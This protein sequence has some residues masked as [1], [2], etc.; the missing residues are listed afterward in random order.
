[1]LCP[2]CRDAHLQMHSTPCGAM[3]ETCPRCRGLW[4]ECGQI[5]E[6]V[7]H[8]EEF[9]K[10]FEHGPSDPHPGDRPCPRCVSPLSEGRLPYEDV[11]VDA[12]PSCGGLWFDAAEV[13]RIVHEEDQTLR[14]DEPAAEAD[15]HVRE[16]AEDRF[17]SLAAG[18]FALPNL[19]LRSA[20]TLTVL[21]GIL[22]LVLITVVQLGYVDGRL[23]FLLG[24][25]FAVCQYTFG[26][27]IMDLSLGYLYAFDWVTPRRLPEHLR[28]FVERV[29]AEHG[30]RFPSFGLIRDGAPAA[31]TYGHHPNN[32]RVVIS[33]GLLE[34]LEPAEVEAVVAHE[35]G[36][37]RNWDMALMTVANLVPFLLYY[38]YRF[39]MDL[40]ARGKGKGKDY[41]WAVSA[42]AYVLFIVSEYIVLWFSRTREYFADRFSGQVTGNANTLASALVKIAYGLAA[43]PQTAEAADDA[44][45]KKS[46]V[47][48]NRIDALG[49]LNIFDRKAAVGLVMA[50]S[51]GTQT[52]LD[53]EQV[54]GAMQWDLWNPWAKY[55]ELHSTHPLVARR[56]IALADHAAQQ[57]HDPFI[58]FDRRKP[59]S[60]W[61]NF[62]V[63]LLILALPT[64]GFLAGLVAFGFSMALNPL[65]WHQNLVWLAWAVGLAGVGSLVKTTFMYR[66]DFSP[67]LAVAALLHKVN[68]S[69]VR[70]VPA[71]LTGKIIGK[72][73]PGLI[74][75]EDFVLKDRTGIIFLNYRQPLAVW[76]WFFGMFRAAQ[77][78]GKEVRVRG[79]Y[80]RSPV[81]FLEL[82]HVEVLDGTLPSRRC[83][84][85]HARIALG[86]LLLAGGLAILAVLMAA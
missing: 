5:Y 77:Y 84:T 36:H 33:R 14:H 9:H 8:P 86:V 58:V 4:M 64:L 81:P 68:V 82:S 25:G 16:K 53:R 60:Y 85:Y 55:Y 74:W 37:A 26:P 49:A 75:S 65:A 7:P 52:E 6:F 47:K 46:E 48:P 11:R 70:P 78:Q 39:T 10:A 23:A 72:G 69:A 50:S 29:C 34:L 54:K 67:H 22:A 20:L 13:G 21:Y 2:C 66:H 32:A 19:F 76:S 18:A 40:N 27:W 56:L 63:D 38:L 3:V 73:V 59:R 24:V 79:W 15:P 35:L 57:G 28:L 42:G 71:T 80:R 45:S 62:L 1:M 83:Y 30:M 41:A 44:K 31:F 61:D 43:Q 12:C 51:A 17:R